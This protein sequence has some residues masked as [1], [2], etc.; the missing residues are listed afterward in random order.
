MKPAALSTLVICVGTLAGCARHELPR[1]ADLPS[2][3]DLPFVHR[4]DVQQGNVVTQEMIAQLAVGMDKKKVN[5]VMGSPIILDTF[6]SGRWDYLYNFQPGH[7]HAER[8]RI[9]LYFADEK[10]ARIEGDVKPAAGKLIVDT[11]QD[12]TVEVPGDFK[13][14]IV[15]RIKNTLPFVGEKR[16]APEAGKTATK[17]ATAKDSLDD[18]PETTVAHPKPTL[19][20]IERAAK[21]DAPGPGVLAKLKEA[22]PFTG[23]KAPTDEPS[24]VSISKESSTAAS[25]ADDQARA[26][27]VKKAEV[28]AEPAKPSMLAKL[29]QALPFSDQPPAATEGIAPKTVPA[30]AEHEHAPTP[31]DTTTHDDS[32]DDG[33]NDAST[34]VVAPPQTPARGPLINELE[35]PEPD[36][37]PSTGEA[38]A[39]LAK[40][41]PE[42]GN[43]VVVPEKPTKKKPGFFS[44]LLGKGESKDDRVE[45][46]NR[47]RRRLKDVTDPDAN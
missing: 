16:L 4:I 35:T 12:M 5:F 47:E 26:E 33:S 32:N 45:P 25:A 31:A 14:G 11:R 15:T 30:D 3:G 19:T 17:V 1:P 18:A 2:F 29:K 10:L 13:P 20:P 24:E 27:K 46:D 9:T 7:G 38:K 22:I 36:L 21:E 6:H 34:V 40:E 43:E 37:Y 8:R 28:A 41:P 44:R 39:A 23:D 42:T